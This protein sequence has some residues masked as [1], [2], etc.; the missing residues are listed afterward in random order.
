MVQEWRSTTLPNVTLFFA[1]RT[2]SSARVMSCCFCYQFPDQ[3]L[4]RR[5]HKIL[6]PP[7]WLR[8]ATCLAVKLEE[9]HERADANPGSLAQFRYRSAGIESLR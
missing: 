7:N 5:Q 1:N 8:D 6:E 4:M 9:A 2:L 3:P